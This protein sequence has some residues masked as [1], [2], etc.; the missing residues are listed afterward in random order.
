MRGQ[1]DV[2]ATVI[3]VTFAVIISSA[4][5]VYMMSMANTALRAPPPVLTYVETHIKMVVL[6]GYPTANG[7]AIDIALVPVFGSQPVYVCLVPVADE[8]GT[9]QSVNP[10]V[11][12]FSGYGALEA[13]QA[14]DT[15]QL[16]AS[17]MILP[18]VSGNTGY[19]TAEIRFKLS[20]VYG[21]CLNLSRTSVF[22]ELVVPQQTYSYRLRIY[23]CAFA[24]TGW[25]TIYAAQYAT[26]TVPPS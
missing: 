20:S 21:A 17:K 7:Y 12:L 19:T 5:A 1:A 4:V 3:L 24:S 18:A 6:A 8:N 22:L 25:G 2:L 14:L 16:D 9:Y 23:L 26:I 11:L 10:T 13:Q 15:T